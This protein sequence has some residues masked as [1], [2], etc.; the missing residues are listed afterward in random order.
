MSNNLRIGESH[1]TC[2]ICIYSK[3]CNIDFYILDFD[4]WNLIE[5]FLKYDILE[6]H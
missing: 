4:V 6:N 3:F 5:V 1:A 2:I